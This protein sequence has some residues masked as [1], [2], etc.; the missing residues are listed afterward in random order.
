MGRRLP[1]NSVWAKSYKPL[2][3]HCYEFRVI[4]PGV[5][6][7]RY[8][9]L[10][11]KSMRSAKPMPSSSRSKNMLRFFGSGED[12]QRSDRLQDGQIL[13]AVR[14]NDY[15]SNDGKDGNDDEKGNTGGALSI[16]VNETAQSASQL[17]KIKLKF[18]TQMARFVSFALYL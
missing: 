9:N 4:S 1:I 18:D 17:H 6:L 16:W 5:V 8:A 3:Y 13:W 11:T 15:Q 2:D 12:K 14:H 10:P 7:D